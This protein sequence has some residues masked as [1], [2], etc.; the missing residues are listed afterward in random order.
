MHISTSSHNEK[1]ENISYI[2][3]CVVV[4]VFCSPNMMRKRPFGYPRLSY[5]EFMRTSQQLDLT[6]VSRWYGGGHH[7]LCTKSDLYQ[8]SR[9]RMMMM[10]YKHICEGNNAKT[11]IVKPTTTRAI[12][13]N[14]KVYITWS[15]TMR[16]YTAAAPSTSQNGIRKR[17]TKQLFFT[18]PA[19][20]KD[21]ILYLVF[22]IFSPHNWCT[23]NFSFFF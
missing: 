11:A 22:I 14:T 18:A 20:K 16:P 4:M 17:N 10:A 9:A 7:F 8:R 23:K 2:F 1:R 3:K 19:R 21:I 6:Y 12:C 13:A 5:S 15:E